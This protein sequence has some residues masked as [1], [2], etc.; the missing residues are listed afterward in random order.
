MRFLS[1]TISQHT[2]KSIY[3]NWCDDGQK[4]DLTRSMTL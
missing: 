4:M 2:S 3:F 1:L